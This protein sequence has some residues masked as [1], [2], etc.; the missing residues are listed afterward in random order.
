DGVEL[1]TGTNPRKRDT[2]SDGV[3]DGQEDTNRNGR[4]DPEET[5]PRRPDRR[6]AEAADLEDLDHD[7][8]DVRMNPPAPDADNDG[9]PDDRDECPDTRASTEVD[10]RG[11][12]VARRS[13]DLSGVQFASNSATLDA[14]SE[15]A[16][17]G[18]LQVL[19][20]NPDTRV[21]IAGHTD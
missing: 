9:V 6:A 10:S 17:Q 5:D 3:P 8:A 15:A 11:C 7:P 2:D 13:M 12:A 21:E 4:V 18:V 20:D 16:L 1:R 19:R 14:R